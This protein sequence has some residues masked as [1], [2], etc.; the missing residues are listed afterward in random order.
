M[1]RTKSLGGLAAL[2]VLAVAGIGGV[3]LLAALVKSGDAPPAIPKL[4]PTDQAPL[5]R[6]ED[7]LITRFHLKLCQQFEM[8]HKGKDGYKMPD[9]G[10]LLERMRLAVQDEI[11]KRHNRAITPQEIA[12]E[13]ARQVRTSRDKPRLNDIIALLDQYPGMYEAIMVRPYLANEAIQK[14]HQDRSIQGG[15]YEK[16]V[17]GLKEA[18]ADPDYFRRMKADAPESY[19]LVDSR[20]PTPGAAPQ[21]HVKQLTDTLREHVIRYANENL[22]S[23]KPG[24]TRQELVDKHGSYQVVQLVE[25]S[26]EHAVYEVVHFR[27]STFDAWF[28][29]ELKKLKGEVVDPE[30]RLLLQ[31]KLKD[32]MYARWLFPQ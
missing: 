11:L 8:V 16:A 26:P 27:K 1:K 28:E 21:E 6:I 30:I 9:Y 19:E 17:Q 25:R 22:A 4:D 10:I 15:V 3:I 23:L 20:N 24:E 18:L 29:S 31:D 12:D 5:I 13:R 32:T 7:K 14:L 2:L